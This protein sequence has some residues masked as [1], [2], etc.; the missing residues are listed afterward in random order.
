[1]EMFLGLLIGAV[2]FIATITAY[3]LG[4]KHGRIVKNDGVPNVN[5][6]PIK[7]YQTVKANAEAKKQMDLF[8]QGI[9]N[10]LNFGEPF[11]RKEG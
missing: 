5:I 1:M 2:F 4:V 9:N 7:T 11:E 8:T 10:V 3:S 6:N